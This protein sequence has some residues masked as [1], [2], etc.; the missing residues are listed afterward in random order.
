MKNIMGFT[1]ATVLLDLFLL[2]FFSKIRLVQEFNHD[3]IG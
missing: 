1:L 2:I 3:N